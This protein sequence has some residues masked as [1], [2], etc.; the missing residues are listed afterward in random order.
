M[1]ITRF[2]AQSRIGVRLA[3]RH[4]GMN[5]D[6]DVQYLQLGGVPVRR[7]GFRVD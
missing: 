4:W 5:P 1:G 3:L 6:G 7:A 2:G